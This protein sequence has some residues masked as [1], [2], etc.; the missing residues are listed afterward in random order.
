MAFADQIA[1]IPYAPNGSNATGI[2]APL[3]RAMG[4]VLYAVAATC[5]TGYTITDEE[6]HS[7]LSH[8]E[9]HLAR[10]LASVHAAPLSQTGKDRILAFTQAIYDANSEWRDWDHDTR[11]ANL[12]DLANRAA[13]LAAYLDFECI[14]L[15]NSDPGLAL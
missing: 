10:T 5:D 7:E 14:G 1:L 6:A 15:H 13:A 12:R 4:H 3:M 2:L 8:A 11:V 9:G